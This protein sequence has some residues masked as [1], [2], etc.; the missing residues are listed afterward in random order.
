MNLLKYNTSFIVYIRLNNSVSIINVVNIFY[1]FTFQTM[2][3]P[4]KRMVYLY[5]LF[6]LLILSVKKVF[7]T[8]FNL[9]PPPNWRFNIQV[10]HE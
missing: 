9:S 6:Q 8:I 5:E 2:N 10:F 1:L 4:K 3:P 7:I